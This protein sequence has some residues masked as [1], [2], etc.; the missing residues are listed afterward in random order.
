MRCYRTYVRHSALPARVVSGLC[1][2]WAADAGVGDSAPLKLKVARL[3]RSI[4][5][6]LVRI[7]HMARGRRMLH[8]SCGTCPID[9]AR[10]TLARRARTCTQKHACAH[11]RRC[12]AHCSSPLAVMAGVGSGLPRGGDAEHTRVHGTLPIQPARIR[13]VLHHEGSRGKGTREYS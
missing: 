2:G 12:G 9:L 5:R 3:G 8:G 11:A 10:R 7:G 6:A 4:K 13:K 1:C